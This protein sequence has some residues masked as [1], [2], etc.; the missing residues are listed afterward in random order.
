[1][2]SLSTKEKQRSSGRCKDLLAIAVKYEAEK[3]FPPKVVASGREMVAE[4]I[5]AIAKESGV[6]IHQ[7][8]EL[9]VILSL[10][11]IGDVIPCE[12]FIAVAEIIAY[13][14]HKNAEKLYDK[15]DH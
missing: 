10:L 11:E 8:K 5:I 14:F 2:T 6:P 4:R 9:A 3:P 1:M 7:N 15:K 12:A 13:I